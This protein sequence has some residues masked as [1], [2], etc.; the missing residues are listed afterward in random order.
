MKVRFSGLMRAIELQKGSVSV[1]EVHNKVLFSRLCQSLSSC[2]GE[3][4]VEP[5]SV[6][7]GENNELNPGKVLLW[8][9]DPF[10]LPWEDKA[11]IG[12]LRSSVEQMVLEDESVRQSI[13]QLSVQLQSA[14]AQLC[15]QI[16]G[17]YRFGLD[18]ELQRYLKAF[19]FHVDYDTDASLLDNLIKY[20]DFVADVMPGKVM[21]FVNLK[22]FLEQNELQRLYERVFFRNMSV[23]LLE[24]VADTLSYNHEVKYVVDQDFLEY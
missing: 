3:L 17:E 10:N 19:N 7:D 23:L 16:E 9:G 4:A 8:V 11:L 22:N 2:K 18:W 15:F 14:I 1:L 13:E 24:S 12:S 20:L 21:V 6:W 5:Y